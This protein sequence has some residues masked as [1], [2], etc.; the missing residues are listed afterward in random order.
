MRTFKLADN[1]LGLL[2]KLKKKRN[3]FEKDTFVN[4]VNSDTDYKMINP[5]TFLKTYTHS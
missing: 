1:P 3:N 4:L 5:E 2:V